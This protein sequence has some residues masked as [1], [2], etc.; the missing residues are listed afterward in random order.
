MGV[1]TSQFSFHLFMAFR[2]CVYH[3][4]VLLSRWPLAA[5]HPRLCRCPLSLLQM[6]SYLCWQ[7]ISEY[8]FPCARYSAGARCQG[9]PSGQ[10]LSVPQTHRNRGYGYHLLR[11]FSGCS[12]HS[13]SICRFRFPHFN[14]YDL[15]MPVLVDSKDNVGCQFANDPVVPDRKMDGI[16]KHDGIYIRQRA[17]LPFLNPGYVLF[18]FRNNLRFKGAVSILGYICFKFP[19]PAAD[20]FWLCAVAVIRFLETYVFVKAEALTYFGLQQSLYGAEKQVF[21]GILNVFCGFDTVFL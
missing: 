21:E 1:M 5:S 8:F 14:R 11:S 7:H 4:S 2:Y 15:L 10:L 20:G 16:N 19:V 13:A 3:F 18:P 12:E 17:V 9:M 6:L